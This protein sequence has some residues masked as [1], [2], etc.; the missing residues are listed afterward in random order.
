MNLFLSVN[1]VLAWAG[2]AGWQAR[3]P[4]SFSLDLRPAGQNA[5][6]RE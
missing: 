3:M 6:R 4:L 1:V 2:A 5:Q